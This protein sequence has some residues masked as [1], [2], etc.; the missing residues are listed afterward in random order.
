ML[1]LNGHWKPY[2]L[3]YTYRSFGPE[4]EVAKVVAVFEGRGFLGTPHK[5]QPGID[6]FL[7]D[8]VLPTSNPQAVQLQENSTGGEPRI[9]TDAVRHENS[10]RDSGFQNVDLY[11]RSND[12]NVTVRSVLR[13]AIDGG[14]NRG[15]QGI[16]GRGIFKTI[17]I[18]TQDGVIRI[19]PDKLSAIAK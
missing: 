8:G 17:T 14:A 1:P 12:K 7:H 10:A 16:T 13:F 6:G 15:F 4:V 18:F 19:R 11:V 9:L 3:V 2:N 5:F